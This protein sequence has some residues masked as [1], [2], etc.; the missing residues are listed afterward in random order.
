M[1]SPSVNRL[2]R[3][4]LEKWIENAIA[5][6]DTLDGDCDLEPELAGFDPNYMDDREGDCERELDMAEM[7]I[8][9]EDAA[10]EYFPASAYWSVQ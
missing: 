2:R 5:L 3:L 8:C 10:A 1:P 4:M 9:D 7:G 6:L